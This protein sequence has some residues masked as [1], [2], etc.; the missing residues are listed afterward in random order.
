MLAPVSKQRAD[1]RQFLARASWIPRSG[2]ST[3]PEGPELGGLPAGGAPPDTGAPPRAAG[4]AGS[5]RAAPAAISQPARCSIEPVRCGPMLHRAGCTTQPCRVPEHTA[6]P[7]SRHPRHQRAA[8]QAAA[9]TR[10]RPPRPARTGPPRHRPPPPGPAPARPRPRPGSGEPLK[11]SFRFHSAQ[12]DT[13]DTASSRV[14][15]VIRTSLRSMRPA[16]GVSRTLPMFCR[17]R[18]RRWAAAASVKG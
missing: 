10:H 15:V 6:R 7:L 1:L 17:C 2:V 18:I 13:P 5:G 11:C 14:T 9:A 8:Q 3:W 16:Q 12:L 4:P